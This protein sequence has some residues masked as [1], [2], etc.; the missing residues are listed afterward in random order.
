[1]GA[2]WHDTCEIRGAEY[3]GFINRSRRWQSVL[4]N[5]L[6]SPCIN[7]VPGTAY[8][9]YGHAGCKIF[10]NTLDTGVNQKQ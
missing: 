10:K 9:L 1:M 4:R 2:R 8:S 7:S 3:C 5:Q 6:K